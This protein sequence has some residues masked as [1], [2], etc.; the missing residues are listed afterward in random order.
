MTQAQQ[1]VSDSFPKWEIRQGD[2]LERLAGLEE[3]SVHCCV[4]SPPYWRLRDYGVTR[5]IGMEDTIDE[6]V[7][8]MVDVFREVRRVLRRDGTLWLNLGDS[9]ITNGWGGGTGGWHGGQKI[10][11]AR[12]DASK[13]ANN[14]QPGLKSKDMAGIP[15]RVAFALQSDGWWLRSDIIWHRKN[16][17]PEAVYDRPTKSHEYIFL[18]S[19]SKKYFYDADAVKCP[20]VE[21]RSAKR[22]NKEASRAFNRKKKTDTR[23]RAD[24]PFNADGE[25]RTTRNLRDVWSIPSQPRSEAHFASFPDE[26][27]RRCILAGCPEDGIVLDPFVGR[28][29]TVIVALRNRRNAIGI[30]LNPEYCEMARKNIEKDAPLFNW[31]HTGESND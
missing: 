23:G 1:N 28:G 27:P 7:T 9:Y 17:M 6:Y 11:K 2:V 30:D 29:T 18:L 3:E 31:N 26:L 25:L 12:L 13:K 15:W 16:P 21:Q 22:Q 10:D 14:K 20:V 5:Q 24:K 19:K 4:T 8:K